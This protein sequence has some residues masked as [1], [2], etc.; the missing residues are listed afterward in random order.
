MEGMTLLFNQ[1]VVDELTIGEERLGS[2]P[3]VSG[4]QVL[5]INFGDHFPEAADEG[6]L[7]D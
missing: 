4:Y 5:G 2:D 3:R 6:G 1:K 7:A